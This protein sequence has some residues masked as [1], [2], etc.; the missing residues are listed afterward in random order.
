MTTPQPRSFIPCWLWLSCLLL[1]A[2]A[3]AA[4]TTFNLL[5]SNDLRGEIA[6]CG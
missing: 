6:P 5:Y 4:P 2:P 1:A 3:L